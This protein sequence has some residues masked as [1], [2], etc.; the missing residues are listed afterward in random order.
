MK[1]QNFS[2][3]K[4]YS[5]KIYG[6]LLQFRIEDMKNYSYIY[7]IIYYIILLIVVHMPKP[8]STP[9]IGMPKKCS[10]FTVFQFFDLQFLMFFFYL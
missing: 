9:F 5:K 2:M 6:N 10:R 1:V 7:F 3:K 8:R 4:K